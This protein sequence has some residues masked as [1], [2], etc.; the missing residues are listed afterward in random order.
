MAL[1]SLVGTSLLELRVRAYRPPSSE[2][3]IHFDPKG[4]H[5]DGLIVEALRDGKRCWVGVFAFGETE[6]DFVSF[7]GISTAVVIA[8]GQA[9]WLNVLEPKNWSISRSQ[10]LE[11]ALSIESCSC[12]VAYDDWCVFVI[13]ASG[14]IHE[15][16][17]DADGI[18]DLKVDGRVV[19]G[20]Y[21]AVS[22]GGSLV[23]F[24]ISLGAD[25]AEE[26]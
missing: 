8:H 6:F 22:K 12:V 23:P 11:G 21:E 5:R 4:R 1:E 3:E 9:Y 26:S 25:G 7:V 20:T 19:V 2:V 18:H 14:E 10:Y 15:H 13:S 17:L 24:S 16:P